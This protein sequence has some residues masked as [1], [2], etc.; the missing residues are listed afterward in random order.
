LITPLLGYLL[1]SGERLDEDRNQTS[2]KE[3]QLLVANVRPK[4][5]E[6]HNCGE[7]GSD[8]AEWRFTMFAKS[9]G[10]GGLGNYSTTWNQDGVHDNST[11]VF[12]PLEWIFVV[13]EGQKV[14]LGTFGVEEDGPFDPNDP[15]PAVALEIDPTAD[16]PEFRLNANSGEFSYTLVWGIDVI[17]H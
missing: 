4:R 12:G 8:G 5:I 11:Q 3:Q 6:V 15:L 14:T 17:G 16:G 13:P 1:V 9:A 2:M 10:G 7:S